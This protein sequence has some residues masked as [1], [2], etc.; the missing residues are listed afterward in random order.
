MNGIE[1]NCIDIENI[2]IYLPNENSSLQH[3]VE[4]GLFSLQTKDDFVKEFCKDIYYNIENT[5]KY[6]LFI[7]IWTIYKY[8]NRYSHSIA[9]H[10]I[11]IWK[12]K[13]IKKNNDIVFVNSKGDIVIDE[14]KYNSISKALRNE[15]KKQKLI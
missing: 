10:G 12:M 11:D 2:R 9:F 7:S 8:V 14:G 4:I 1:I 15:L 13:M 6:Q 3:Q 5:S